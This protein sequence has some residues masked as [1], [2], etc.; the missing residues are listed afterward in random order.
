M[1]KDGDVRYRV[2]QKWMLAWWG[3]GW[4]GLYNG[5]HTASYHDLGTA[6][7][8][9]HSFHDKDEADRATKNKR[10]S[11]KSKVVYGPYPP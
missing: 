10:R 1:D 11:F 5:Y 8:Y 4:D 9:L 2:E 3:L 6:K 7:S